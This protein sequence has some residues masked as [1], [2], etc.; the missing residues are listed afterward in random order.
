MPAMFTSNEKLKPL[1]QPMYPVESYESEKMLWSVERPSSSSSS[2]FFIVDKNYILAL[3]ISVKTYIRLIK[4][5]TN[6]K[7]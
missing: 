7:T 4:V 2:N 1:R 5:N 6:N 3:I